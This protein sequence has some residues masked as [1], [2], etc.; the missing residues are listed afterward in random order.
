MSLLD[1]IRPDFEEL[2]QWG[3]DHEPDDN[4]RFK[5]GYW[6]SVIFM[7]DDLF[8]YPFWRLAEKAN[9]CKVSVIGTHYSKSIELPVVKIEYKSENI[10]LEVLLSYNFHMWSVTVRCSHPI[11]DMVKAL[12]LFDPKKSSYCGL[13]GFNPA[14]ELQCYDENQKEFSCTVNG[15]N[16]MW[17]FMRIV[18][19]MA[20]SCEL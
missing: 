13:Y 7:R 15:Y 3:V 12:K 16:E 19:C 1:T 8:T 4:M 18:T 14:D 2:R 10:S 9:L 17:T 5:P 20:E 11:P 6:H